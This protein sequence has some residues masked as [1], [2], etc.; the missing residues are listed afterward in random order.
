MNWTP[1]RITFS[2]RP[3][4]PMAIGKLRASKDR[5]D[6]IACCIPLTARR[7]IAVL[8]LF[9]LTATPCVPC[10]CSN[11]KQSLDR[12]EESLRSAASA[13]GKVDDCCPSCEIRDELRLSYRACPTDRGFE[14]LTQATQTCRVSECDAVQIARVV[15]YHTLVLSNRPDGVRILLE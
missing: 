12:N 4:L 7:S 10:P 3:A 14:C 11:R 15:F 2:F 6:V 9:S 1:S 5:R 13:T 8:L